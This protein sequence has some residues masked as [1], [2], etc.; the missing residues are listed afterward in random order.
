MPS[1]FKLSKLFLGC[2]SWDLVV[3]WEIFQFHFTNIGD[4]AVAVERLLYHG[5]NNIFLVKSM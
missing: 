3:S 5:A 1:N 4:D 2:N